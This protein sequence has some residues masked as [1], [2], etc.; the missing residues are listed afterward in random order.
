MYIPFDLESDQIRYVRRRAD[1]WVEHATSTQRA[2]AAGALFL[3]VNARS[4]NTELA[5]LST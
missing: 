2:G 3:P 5:N 1:F 4:T